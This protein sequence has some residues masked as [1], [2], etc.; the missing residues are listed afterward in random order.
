MHNLIRRFI[1]YIAIERGL[2][3]ATI[4]AYESD[5]TMYAD[6]LERHGIDDVR[7]VT[8]DHVEQFIA[9]T[10]EQG[11]STTSIARRLASIHMFHRFVTGEGL[12]DSDPSANVK[13]PKGSQ[14]LPDVLTVEQVQTLLDAAQP[15]A[16]DPVEWRDKALL[17]F[18]YAT[19][20]RVSEAVNTDLSD[21]DFDEH[22]VRLTGK[23]N[24]QRLVPFG[25][26]ARTALQAYVQRGRPQLEAKAKS[27]PER[28]AVFLNKRGARLSRQSAWEAIAR[29][30]QRAQLPVPLHPHTLRHSFAT[31]LLAGGADVRTVQEL[32]GH[33]SVN[34]TQRYTH[35]TPDALI[36]TYI[37]S[38]PRARG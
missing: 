12:A 21:I 22:V 16:D 6:W 19:G 8:S 28:R 26:Y 24:K 25:S 17:E 27:T 7:N 13:P 37:M 38:H 29:A 35:V 31:H 23:G 10:H 15:I 32:L 1:D 30:G 34:T 20:C 33:S 9:W 2:S 5:L 11:Q 36:E 4:S 14:T 3:P 18:M